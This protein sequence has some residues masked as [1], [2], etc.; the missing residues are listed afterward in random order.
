[1]TPLLI[2][3]RQVG[4]VSGSGASL[5]STSSRLISFFVTILRIR[6]DSVYVGLIL[7]TGI[8]S[9]ARDSFHLDVMTCATQKC[10]NSL[11]S[12]HSQLFANRLVANC[13]IIEPPIYPS[14]LDKAE[15]VTRTAR[16]MPNSI[17][18]AVINL[19]TNPADPVICLDT[20]DNRG[21]VSNGNHDYSDSFHDCVSASS[22]LSLLDSASLVT[23]PTSSAT[24]ETHVNAATS[25][26]NTQG[27]SSGDGTLFDLQ[28]SGAQKRAGSLLGLAI[29]IL[30]GIAW[31]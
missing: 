6:S 23:S 10:H 11:E 16:L 5:A 12:H 18:P 20:K 17:A 7:K 15:E 19:V 22:A 21:G 3:Q 29:S 13:K 2:V 31:F 9:L 14:I 27:S 30:V 24:T 26:T 4:S 28:G 8:C 1:M 25:P